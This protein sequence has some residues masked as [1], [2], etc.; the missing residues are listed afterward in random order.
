[1]TRLFSNLC[2]D[3]SEKNWWRLTLAV[4]AAALVSVGFG[5]HAAEAIIDAPL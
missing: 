5:V 3:D 4:G 1:M 2:V